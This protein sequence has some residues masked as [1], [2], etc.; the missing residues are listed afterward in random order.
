M[1]QLIPVSYTNFGK[2]QETD[3]YEGSRSGVES[4]CAALYA[5]SPLFNPDNDKK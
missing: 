1:A 5:A 3:V 4:S 2:E